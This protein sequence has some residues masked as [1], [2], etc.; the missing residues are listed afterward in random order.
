MNGYHV[1]PCRN[2]GLH[3]K[4]AWE[5]CDHPIGYNFAIFHQDTSK[6]PHNGW[7]VTDL[8]ARADRNLITASGYDLWPQSSKHYQERA[9]EL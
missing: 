9:I 3:V 4:V 5:K 6:I 8:E 2:D 1:V 7:V